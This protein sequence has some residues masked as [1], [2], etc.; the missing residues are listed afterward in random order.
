[1]GVHHPSRMSGP[2]E[3]AFTTRLGYGC[4][5]LWSLCEEM[6]VYRLDLGLYS[7]PKEF[8]C[9]CCCCCK[10][11]LNP[12]KLQGKNPLY[13]KKISSE[14]D[15]THDAALSRTA[16]L[17]HYQPAV[18]TPIKQDSQPN[19]L[20]TSY[21]GP[22]DSQPNTLPKSCSSPH[23]AGQPAQHTANQLFRPPSS[24]TASPTHCQPAIPAPIN[25][26]ASPTHCQPAIPA[27]IN[28]TASPTHCQGAVPAP[29][30]VLIVYF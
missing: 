24:R 5:D 12:C 27:S 3:W 23:Q 19:T 8:C 7:H 10:W 20:P 1:M 26:T 22:Q 29:R 18:P 6:H 13:R 21:S 11:S 28:R 16:S 15:R 17:T 25:R 2:L 14:E 9:C 4:Q 30:Q